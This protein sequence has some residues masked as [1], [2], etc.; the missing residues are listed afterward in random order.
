MF[1]D[2]TPNT[3][4][5]SN[6]GHEVLPIEPMPQ[7]ADLREHSVDAGQKQLEVT[8]EGHSDFILNNDAALAK[9]WG[10]RLKEFFRDGVPLAW[11]VMGGGGKNVMMGEI[12]GKRFVAKLRNKRLD[13]GDLRMSDDEWGS[14]FGPSRRVV[15][16]DESLTSEMHMAPKI[17]EALKTDE[18]HAAIQESGTGISGVMLA[19]P[20]MGVVSRMPNPELPYAKH[21]TE[22]S[23]HGPTADKFIVYEWLEGVRPTEQQGNALMEIVTE[24]LHRGNVQESDLRAD[25]FIVSPSGTA[26]LMDTEEFMDL[27]NTSAEEARV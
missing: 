23:W 15:R 22:L 19:E 13:D 14:V 25:Q 24:G 6:E 16:A 27:T 10:P 4:G 8:H 18:V 20:I 5:F 3:A 7:V 21:L 12:D 2:A 1:K 9:E 17:K 26:Y 11:Q